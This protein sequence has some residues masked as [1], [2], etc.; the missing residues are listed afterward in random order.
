MSTTKKTIS[1]KKIDSLKANKVD[2]KK[3]KG[4]ISV[5][6]NNNNSGGSNNFSGACEC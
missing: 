5:T 2:G 4:G 1:T 3:V 6:L